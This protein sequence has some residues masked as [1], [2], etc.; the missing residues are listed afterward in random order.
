MWLYSFNLII[1]RHSDLDY[2]IHAGLSP[3]VFG[4]F[5]PIFSLVQRWIFA[6][7]TAKLATLFLDTSVLLN[8]SPFGS[9]HNRFHF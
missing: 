4:L 8:C 1:L 7:L 6:I 2:Y 5:T 3:S 9:L